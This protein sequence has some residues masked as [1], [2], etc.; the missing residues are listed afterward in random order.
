MHNRMLMQ[1]LKLLYK[2]QL[3]C[4]HID[5]KNVLQSGFAITVKKKCIYLIKEH[6]LKCLHGLTSLLGY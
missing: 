4:L 1:E 3:K 5:I 2:Y 6:S